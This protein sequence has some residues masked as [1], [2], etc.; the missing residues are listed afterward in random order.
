MVSRGLRC[1]M[2]DRGPSTH[3]PSES[4]RNGGSNSPTICPTIFDGTCH[5][6]V[7]GPPWMSCSGSTHQA[8]VS[9]SATHLLVG[10][11]HGI[12]SDMFAAPPAHSSVVFAHCG[13][14]GSTR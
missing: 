11:Q 14:A 2:L 12:R 1:R 4:S 7:Y 9:C 5:F 10:L 8:Y 13:C 3:T 6:G